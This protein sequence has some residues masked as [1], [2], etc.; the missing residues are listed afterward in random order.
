M[1]KD[2]RDEQ[3]PLG[4][5]GIMEQTL[6]WQT[7]LCICFVDIEK[8]FDSVDHQSGTFF[9]TLVYVPGEIVDTVTL[10]YDEFTCQVMHNGKLL[11]E[12][13]VTT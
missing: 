1:D 11:E 7:S 5:P 2:L 10:L 9:N 13:E 8:A 4:P 6:K 12:F 3:V